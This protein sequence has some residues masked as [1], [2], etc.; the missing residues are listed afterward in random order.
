MIDADRKHFASRCMLEMLARCE[1]GRT[2]ICRYHSWAARATRKA[3]GARLPRKARAIY[4]IA[5]YYLHQY[6]SLRRR[7]A[8]AMRAAFDYWRHFILFAPFSSVIRDAS[9]IR[10]RRTFNTYAPGDD[11]IAPSFPTHTSAPRFSR[12][13]TTLHDDISPEAH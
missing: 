2:W 10:R 1:A 4:S 5:A 7:Q 3:Q 6:F 9:S 11:G 13:I 12:L 8:T